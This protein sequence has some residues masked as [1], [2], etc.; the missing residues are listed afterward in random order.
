MVDS[1]QNVVQESIFWWTPTHCSTVVLIVVSDPIYLRYCISINLVLVLIM[2]SPQNGQFCHQCSVG[3]DFPLDNSKIKKNP[4]NS[5]ACDLST[6][7]CQSEQIIEHMHSCIKRRYHCSIADSA[8]SAK[9]QHRGILRLV[10]F[11]VRNISK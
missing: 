4:T 7:I 2:D 8:E 3:R 11:S 10:S 6:V 9:R 5:Y 1:Y